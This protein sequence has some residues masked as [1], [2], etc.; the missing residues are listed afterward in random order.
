[1]RISLVDQDK[2]ARRR[3]SQRRRRKRSRTYDAAIAQPGIRSK[4]WPAKRRPSTKQQ[5]ANSR[6]QSERP[7]FD[8]VSVARRGIP[9]SLILARTPVLLILAGL[10]GAIIYT[11]TAMEFFV[12]E[13]E[14]LGARHLDPKIVYGAAEIHEQNI[15]WI[16]PDKVVE[17]ISQLDGIKAVYVRCGLP[18]KVTI[19]VEEREPIIMW[20]ALSQER[21]WWLD[22][23]GV[24]LPYHG[25]IHSP[26]T[27]FVVDSSERHLQVGDRI[28]PDGIV[29]SVQQLA[30][31]LP[32]IEVLFYESDRGLSFTFSGGGAEWPIFV[33]DSQDLQRKIQ[34]VQALTDYLVTN[35]VPTRYVDVRWA[36]YPVYGKPIGESTAGGE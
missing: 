14:I 23:E 4:P 19:E 10:I 36:D 5:R 11:S 35:N 1:M 16:R 22:Q 15:F 3:R 30:A 24:V 29:Q 8:E 17:R 33:G 9:W 34:A 13:G 12:Y 2:E 6:P 32:E 18:A 20:R 7:E 21:D 26:D 31:A 25:D 28:E 27:V